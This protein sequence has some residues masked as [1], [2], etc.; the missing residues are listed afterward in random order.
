M[1]CVVVAGAIALVVAAAG[2]QCSWA[3]GY[4]VVGKE[5][6]EC[7]PLVSRGI[8]P[9]TLNKLKE[10]L[11][12]DRL[13]F[14]LDRLA[15]DGRALMA[16]VGPSSQQ[17]VGAGISPLA[18]GGAVKKEKKTPFKPFKKRVKKRKVK[19]PARAK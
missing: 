15:A 19:I 5:K 7:G 13:A 3:V 18:E 16:Q 6:C 10:A 1:R 4:T 14:I 8:I 2:A 11:F 17:E 9:D 12:L